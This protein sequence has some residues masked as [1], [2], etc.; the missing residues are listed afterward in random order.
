MDVESGG[1]YEVE[2]YK[3]YSLAGIPAVPAAV[4]VAVGLE[5]AG[6]AL[7]NLSF[8]GSALT[9][10]EVGPLRLVSVNHLL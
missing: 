4:L 5:P 1:N 7:R 9:V 2:R 3:I 10:R 6:R 8:G